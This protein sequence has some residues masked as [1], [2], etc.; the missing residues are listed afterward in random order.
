[1]T[2]GFKIL[3]AFGEIIY[4]ICL[5]KARW[6]ASRY[7]PA[8]CVDC[9]VLFECRDK[10]NGYK[11]RKGC[12][13]INSRVWL[14]SYCRDCFLLYICRDEYHDYKFRHNKCLLHKKGEEYKY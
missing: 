12:L 13:A 5:G 10:E 8:R 7:V 9:R 3:G 1:M 14:H 6:K 11:C 2:R 4:F